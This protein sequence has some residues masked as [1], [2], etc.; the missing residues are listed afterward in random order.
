LKYKSEMIADVIKKIKYVVAILLC[1][2]QTTLYSQ[3]INR[4][5]VN[6]NGTIGNHNIIFKNYKNSPGLS[7]G[8]AINLGIYAVNN[9][10]YR[11]GLAFGLLE[12]ASRN[13]NRRKVSEDFV[14]VDTNFDKHIIFNFAQF[15]SGNIGWFSEF[16]FGD[17]ST[18]YHQ[19]GFG[20]FGTTEKDQL[21]D[22]GMSHQLGVLIGPTEGFRTRIGVNF[23]TSFGTGNPNYLQR[24]IGLSIGGHLSI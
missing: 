21:L 5:F 19:V 22:F 13:I 15:R 17:R 12:A 16:S 1:I 20:I 9:P 6:I 24:N 2:S 18:I 7:F 3:K 23:D 8:Y 14:L 10:K 11:G 4:L